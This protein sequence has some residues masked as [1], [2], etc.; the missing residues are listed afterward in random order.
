MDNEFKRCYIKIRTILEIGSKTIHE[1][2]VVDVEPSAPSYIAV[3]RWAKCFRQGREDVTDHPRFARLHYPNLQVKILN[4]FDKL[5]AMIHIQLMMKFYLT[6][7][8]HHKLSTTASR[9]K[10]LHLAG[11][12]IK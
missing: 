1:E 7:L 6:S 9:R 11:Y 8:S 10:E 12:P 3:T 5:S 4:C 2:L